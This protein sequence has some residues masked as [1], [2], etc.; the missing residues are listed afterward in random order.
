MTVKF[1]GQKEVKTDSLQ[2]HPDNPNR[3]SVDDLARSLEQFGQFRSIVGRPDGTILAGH[4]LVEAAK[5]I[6]MATV[7]VDI[8]ETDDKTARKIMLA[9]NRLADLGLGPNLDLLLENLEELDGDLEGTG[10]DVEYLKMLEEAIQGAPDL[11]EL[12]EEA[13]ESEAKAEDF[14]RRLT[15]LVDPGLATRWERIRKLYADDTAAF[16]SLLEKSKDVE[17]AEA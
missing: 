7:R 3:G 2:A 8:I 14:Y 10:F 9:D 12:E 4:H 5:Q 11:D 16:A 15:L 17:S 6:G 13:K 1:I